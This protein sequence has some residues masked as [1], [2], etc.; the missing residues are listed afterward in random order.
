MTQDSVSEELVTEAWSILSCDDT[1][2]TKEHTR[3]ALNA[4]APRLRAEGM[5][6]AAEVMNNVPLRN[7]YAAI[8][9]R[10]QEL[11]PK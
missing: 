7:G 9:A 2:I 6:E 8:L 5:R 10:A 3:L 4:I 11:D 1:S